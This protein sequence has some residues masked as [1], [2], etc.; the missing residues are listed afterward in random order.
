MLEVNLVTF[1]MH[2]ETRPG[3]E[4]VKEKALQSED[5]IILLNN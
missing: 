2:C 3:A 4:R 5:M 1:V